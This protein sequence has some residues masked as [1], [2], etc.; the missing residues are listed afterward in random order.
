[1]TDSERT[2]WD[3]AVDEAIE[4]LISEDTSGFVLAAV[5]GEDTHS[6]SAVS[7]MDERLLAVF[8]VVE[9]VRMLFAE[10]GMEMDPFEVVMAAGYMAEQSGY[11]DG[12]VTRYETNQ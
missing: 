10:Q 11:L 8:I 3:D 12:E 9:E 4:I 7:S 5:E 1:M 2:D 6:V